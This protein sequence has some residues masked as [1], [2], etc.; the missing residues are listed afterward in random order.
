MTDY[1]KP[2][3][4][5]GPVFSFHTFLFPFSWV[6]RGKDEQLFEEQTKLTD[7]IDWMQKSPKRWHRK[8]SWLK[9]KTAP[10]Y[11][12]TAYFYEFVRPVLYDTGR[13]NSLQAHYA[14]GLPV[15][16]LAEYVIEKPDSTS[17]RLVVD[18][19]TV[20]F[21]NNGVGVVA[22][23]LLNKLPE[24]S[25]PQAILDINFFGRRL[26]PPFL[27]TDLSKVGTQAFFSVEQYQKTP[28]HEEIVQGKSPDTYLSYKDALDGMIKYAGELARSI[29]I[30]ADGVAYACDDFTSWETNLDLN[31]PPELIA[32]LLHYEQQDLISI[33]PILDERMYAVS[34]Y[35]NNEL[36]ES[37]Q[38]IHAIVEWEAEQKKEK[39][40]G[41]PIDK[42]AP[43]PKPESDTYY[44]THDWWYKYVFVDK[45]YKSVGHEGFMG[46][47][48][49]KATYERWIGDGT[50][51]GVSRYSF[52]VLTGEPEL[53]SKQELV[54]AESD[55]KP[56]PFPTII[57]THAQTMYQKL[58]VLCMVQRAGLLRFSR[59][60]TNI[61]ELE[62]TQQKG[63]AGRIGSLYKAYLKFINKVY[64]REVSAQEQG[65]ELY[66]MMQDQMGLPEQVTALQQEMQELHQY[67]TIIE[68]EQRN[69]KLDL[70]TYVAALFVV[71][72]FIGGYF[73]IAD[74]DLSEQWGWISL[75][76]FLSAGLAFGAIK[77]RP[78][79]RRYWLIGLAILMLAIISLF[80]LYGEIWD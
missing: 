41:Q 66:T 23:H 38:G 16:E 19:V 25:T 13:K 39:E 76:C 55:R 4:G 7:I 34:W 69:N 77:C 57:L 32:D 5:V 42:I 9:T 12:E 64:F 35:G 56:N 54:E 43:K 60:I 24:Q 11:N 18:D 45:Q 70:L 3:V 53:R 73:G 72:G 74:Y 29:R 33:S 1:K 2:I 61:S 58:A 31:R 68:E 27:N 63:I 47:L 52:V 50:I 8:T 49:K 65:I 30:E 22:F 80:P 79:N 51:Y 48:L 15:G 46:D 36:V 78:K 14:L 37:I 28:T 59:E 67:A 26:Y 17:L 10:A 62:D 71:P 6:Y 20:S 40:D 21:Y 44:Q 75:F